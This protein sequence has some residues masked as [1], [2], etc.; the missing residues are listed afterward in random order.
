MHDPVCLYI[1]DLSC[2]ERAGRFPTGVGS[3]SLERQQEAMKAEG[4]PYEMIC[5]G[6]GFPGGAAIQGA[7]RRKRGIQRVRRYTE[8]LG[9][10]R[11][12]F[13]WQG[14]IADVWPGAHP[15]HS[16]AMQ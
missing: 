4:V 6:T 2:A 5:D 16:T 12:G 1:C 14:D 11:S 3:P 10:L 9:P 8:A 7:M 13:K 15:S